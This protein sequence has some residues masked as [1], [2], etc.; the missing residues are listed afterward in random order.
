MRA[1]VEFELPDNL[2]D[3]DDAE[4]NSI[5]SERI[6]Q[7]GHAILHEDE[8]D[9]YI[10]GYH[11]DVDIPTVTPQAIAVDRRL[12]NIAAAALMAFDFPQ[13]ATESAISMKKAS[14]VMPKM[15]TADVAIGSR[16]KNLELIRDLVTELLDE[17]ES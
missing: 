17:C 1:L 8:F 13:P 15:T 14:R 11:Y 4:I 6:M 2:A 9:G 16:K 5:V 12:E 7:I 10:D 3:E